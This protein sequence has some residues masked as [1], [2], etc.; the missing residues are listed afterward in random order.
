MRNNRI[1]SI[2]LLIVIIF[3]SLGFS[4]IA[5]SQAVVEQLD[6]KEP[7]VPKNLTVSMTTE[8]SI[9]IKWDTSSHSTGIKEYIVYMNDKEVNRTPECLYTAVDLIPGKNYNFYIRAISNNNIISYPSNQIG[10]YTKNDNIKPTQP[11]NLVLN[12]EGSNKVRLK[13]DSSTDNIKLGGYIIYNGS[14][15]MDVSYDPSILLDYL[16]PGYNYNFKV[17]AVDIAG[18]Q[19]LDS[20]SVTYSTYA[21]SETV[22]DTNVVLEADTV[23]DNVI[24]KS[25]SLN[26]NGRKLTVKGNLIN[27][28]GTL[29]INNGYL[30]VN[31]NLRFQSV[32]TDNSGLRTYGSSSSVLKMLNDSDYI[33]VYGSFVCNSSGLNSDNL[34]AGNLEVKRHFIQQNGKNPLNSKGTHKVILSGDEKQNVTMESNTSAFNTLEIKN[35]SA[36]G[37]LFTTLFNCE[38]FVDNMSK[39]SF[40]DGGVKGWRLN[41][42]Q[43]IEGDLSLAAGTLDLNGYTL[44]IKG[45][46]RQSGGNVFVNNGKLIIDKDYSL[47]GEKDTNS[48]PYSTGMLKMLLPKDIVLVGG[49]FT[50]FSI[51]NHEGLLTEGVLEVKGDIYQKNGSTGNFTSSNNHKVVLS[52]EKPQNISFEYSNKSGNRINILLRHSHTGSACVNI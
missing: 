7:L 27:S 14:T 3:N 32:Y 48:K 49:N 4:E 22:I 5:Y 9:G 12:E 47:V 15:G 33:K 23:Y 17:R 36:E 19:S 30:E 43:T 34:T 8:T 25:G 50:T 31:G 1:V 16:Q 18:N 6:L 29:Y 28:G 2:V 37:V 41:G 24:I 40:F 44:N 39:A 20:N 42:D 26:L 51:H 11:Q 35:T 38:N 45:S 10:I 52:G 21:M 13:W 46:L